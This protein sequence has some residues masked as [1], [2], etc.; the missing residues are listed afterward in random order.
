MKKRPVVIGIAI[1]IT[2]GILIYINNQKTYEFMLGN[3]PNSN[4]KSEEIQPISTTV[5]VSGDIDTDV[6]FTD[7]ETGE[8]Y[9]IGYI[10]QGLTQ[11]IKLEKGKW[12][13]VEGAGNI[14]VSNVN[15]RIE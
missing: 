4:I 14:T 10:T 7:V 15:V 5:K 1:L 9:K 11:E 6:V 12:Y 3:Q 2:I 13:R 8:S